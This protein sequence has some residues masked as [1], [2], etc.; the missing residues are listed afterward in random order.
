MGR[1]GREKNAN[2]S[3]LIPVRSHNIS[4]Y[5]NYLVLTVSTWS[6]INHRNSADPTPAYLP[7][8]DRLAYLQGMAGG[9]LWK[10]NPFVD[11]PA[12]PKSSWGSL[13]L[14]QGA[15]PGQA[16]AWLRLLVLCPWTTAGHKPRGAGHKH[17]QKGINLSCTAGADSALQVYVHRGSGLLLWTS[18]RKIGHLLVL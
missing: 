3:L 9:F 17:V 10:E 13:Q 14:R 16:L 15:K 7:A 5:K 1:G 11:L 2:A 18:T 8:N 12:A 6:R 4:N